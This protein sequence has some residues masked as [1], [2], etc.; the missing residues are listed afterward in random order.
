MA[1]NVPQ[2]LWKC[3]AVL[4]TFQLIPETEIKQADCVYTMGLLLYRTGCFDEALSKI[5]E[6]F[7]LYKTKEGTECYQAFCL[8]DGGRILG[9]MGR[10]IKALENCTN[11]H[12]LFS[13]LDDATWQQ[14]SC[15]LNSGNAY[16][17]LGM[18][19]EALASYKQAN[20]TFVRLEGTRK[21]QAICTMNSGAVLCDLA[22]YEE[23]IKALDEAH[24]VFASLD[25]AKLEQAMSVT[26]LGNV[27]LRLKRYEEALGRYREGYNLFAAKSGTKV[28]QAKCLQNIGTLLL[29][30][31]QYE[32]ALVSSEKAGC[33]FAAMGGREREQASC[34]MNSG[35]ILHSLGRYREALM[36]HEEAARLLASQDGTESLQAQNQIGIGMAY[37]FLSQWSN[38]LKIGYKGYRQ[39]WEFLIPNLPSL[40]E[41]Q[42]RLFLSDRLVVPDDIYSISLVAGESLTDAGRYGLDALLLSKGL[43]EYAMQQEQAVFAEQAPPEWQ[44]EYEELLQWRREKAT[45]VHMLND[46][47][48]NANI[49]D[50]PEAREARMNRVEELD[51]QIVAREQ[52]LAQRIVAFA[53]EMRLQAVDSG[54]VAE[55]LSHLDA[56]AALL[57]YVKY[58]EW[59][60]VT[61]DSKG[62][63]YGVYVL[64]PD[65]KG[66][67]GLT[68]S[69]GAHR[70]GNTTIPRDRG[71]IAFLYWPKR[72]FPQCGYVE[73]NDNGLHRG[74]TCVARIGFR[75]GASPHTGLFASVCGAGC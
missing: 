50:T 58:D 33:L 60:F 9:D 41:E 56:D 16:L 3:T 51:T 6:A 49:K 70:R 42:K 7:F 12:N 29:G 14:A 38:A 17:G 40:T 32:Q 54:M 43:V 61:D 27:L 11:A 71:T 21:E 55:A 26:N 67:V 66:A 46:V 23:A 5:E 34:I 72:R 59:D 10:Y 4:E 30:L 69:G 18:L 64:R 63:R 22:R 37:S 53:D 35:L 31:K 74:G 24:D 73:G 2:N 47:M 44:Q 13:T 75:S 19:T 52:D 15:I 39:A 65:G 8:L 45:L 68:L 1:L 28:E 48:Y 20:N 57:E 36:A 25:E 62:L